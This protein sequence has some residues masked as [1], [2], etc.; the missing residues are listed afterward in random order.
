M[1]LEMMLFFSLLIAI[2]LL[3][4]AY[5]LQEKIDRLYKEIAKINQDHKERQAQTEDIMAKNRE[6]MKELNA[7][8]NV[9][10]ET[11][12]NKSYGLP[13]VVDWV[14]QQYPT[15]GDK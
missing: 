5:T 4:V 1:I 7:K 8:Q 12:Y 2:V 11:S 3:F 9:S 13:E 15:G 14:N 10:R 6:L